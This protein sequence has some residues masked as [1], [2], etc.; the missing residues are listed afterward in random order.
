MDPMSLILEEGSRRGRT[1]EVAHEKELPNAG[2][3]DRGRH[4][5]PR[6]VVASS[7][8]KSQEQILP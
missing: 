6:N 5:K 7:S 2:F 8:W 3:E 4:P 1:R